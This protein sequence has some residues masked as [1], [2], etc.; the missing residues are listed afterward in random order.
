MARD[1]KSKR[2]PPGKPKP[3]TDVEWA[4]MAVVWEHEPCAAGTVQEALHDNHGWAYS[5][6]KTTMDRMVAKGLLATHSIRNLQ[7][8]APLITRTEAKR[9][10]LRRL[11]SRAFNGA[12]T[13]MIQFLVEDEGLSADELKQL[14]KLLDFRKG[15]RHE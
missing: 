15:Q 7:M 11:L 4:I 2:S 13:P 3:L 10:E 9:A 14:R 6:V 12:L 1:A 8:F 5:T